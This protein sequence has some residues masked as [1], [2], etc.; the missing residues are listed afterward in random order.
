M[1][2][3]FNPNMPLAEILQQASKG[4]LFFHNHGHLGSYQILER[5]MPEFKGVKHFYVEIPEKLFKDALKQHF[6]NGSSLDQAFSCFTSSCFINQEQVSHLKDLIVAAHKVGIEVLAVDTNEV[7]IP[8]SLL[9]GDTKAAEQVIKQRLAQDQKVVALMKTYM[10]QLKSEDKYIG[11]FGGNHIGIGKSFPACVVLFQARNLEPGRSLHHVRPE[12]IDADPKSA[13]II[14]QCHFMTFVPQNLDD[15]LDLS[16][17]VEHKNLAELN[18][19]LGTFSLPLCQA[20]RHKNS[21]KISAAV[22]IPME[23]HHQIWGNIV[24]FMDPFVKRC[25]TSYDPDKALIIFDDIAQD[26]VR[27]KIVASL[28]H[29]TKSKKT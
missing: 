23:Q 25:D 1:I 13:A 21:Q 6:T 7:L 17:P 18:R 12:D 22:F 24:K 29:V 14:N 20:Y 15:S 16:Q 5:A 9:A 11:L 27:A 2:A 4:A 28:V 3:N 19:L 10:Q 26:S 8:D